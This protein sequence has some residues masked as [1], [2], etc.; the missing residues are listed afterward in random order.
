MKLVNP[1]ALWQRWTTLRTAVGL[2]FWLDATP[3]RLHLHRSGHA[4][5]NIGVGIRLCLR[6]KHETR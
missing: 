4:N 1:R 2:V 6:R 5:A 3:A